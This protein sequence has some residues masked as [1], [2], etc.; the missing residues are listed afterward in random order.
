[1]RPI[2]KPANK[3][4]FPKTLKKLLISLNI[5]PSFLNHILIHLF[6]F[7]IILFFEVISKEFIVKCRNYVKKQFLWWFDTPMKWIT[8]TI[9]ICGYCYNK[10][11]YYC[12]TFELKPKKFTDIFNLY[13]HVLNQK[14]C[15]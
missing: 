2:A 14:G 3:M 8:I 1:M 15:Y 6:T 12:K 10:M 9:L 4:S 13:E 11:V 5:V 7:F